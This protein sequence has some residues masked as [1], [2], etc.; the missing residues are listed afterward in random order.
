MYKVNSVKY[1]LRRNLG[2]YEHEELTVELGNDEESAISV[3]E[4]LQAARVACITN[5][6]PYIRKHGKK[7]D[8]LE[9]N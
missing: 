8:E 2:N 3:D 5:S 1:T 6:T 7:A 4:L 9:A